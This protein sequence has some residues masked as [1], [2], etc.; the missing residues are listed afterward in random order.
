MA[1]APDLELLFTAAYPRLVR[2]LSLSFGPEIAEEAVADAFVQADLQWRKVGAYE[3]P[4]AWIRRVAINKALDA[5]RKETRRRRLHE[6]TGRS[7]EAS[8]DRPSDELVDLRRAMQAMTP[9]IRLMFS[10]FYLSGLSVEE[11]AQACRV[12]AGTVKS[13]LHEARH[14]VKPLAEEH[15]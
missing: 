10:L 5:S 15:P 9:R 11:V 3:D 13:T 1:S 6:Q 2:A 4:S 12:S 7:E 8:P 14:R